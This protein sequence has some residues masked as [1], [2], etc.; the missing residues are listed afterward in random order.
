VTILEETSKVT[1]AQ[2]KIE[3]SRSNIKSV[4][5]EKMRIMNEESLVK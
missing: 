1:E 5:E 2:S 4:E 3:A